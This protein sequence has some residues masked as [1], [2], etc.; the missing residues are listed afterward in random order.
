[1]ICMIQ[2]TIHFIM[3]PI[4]HKGLVTVASS[5]KYLKKEGTDLHDGFC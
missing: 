2:I 4:T 5:T 3:L 1:M